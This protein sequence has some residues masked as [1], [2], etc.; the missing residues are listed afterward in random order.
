MNTSIITNKN[1]DFTFDS[2]PCRLMRTVIRVEKNPINGF[3]KY[4]ILNERVKYVTEEFKDENDETQE[5]EVLKV[6]D[7]K[8]QEN[9]RLY[10]YEQINQLFGMIKNLIPQDLD[11]TTTRDVEMQ[12]A[13]LMM[14]K[15]DKPY[16]TN[17]DDWEV[18]NR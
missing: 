1:V 13:L 6:I 9:V 10:R 16:N 18:L 2:E 17:A 14:T 15:Q 4:V 5:R 3:E 11:Y 8:D 7:K 12:L